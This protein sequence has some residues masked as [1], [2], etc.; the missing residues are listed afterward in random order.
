MFHQN[1]AVIYPQNA[2]PAHDQE[3]YFLTKDFDIA[4]A[5]LVREALTWI[6]MRQSNGMLYSQFAPDPTGAALFG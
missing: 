6:D 5:K 3:S 4:V 2:F 1:L